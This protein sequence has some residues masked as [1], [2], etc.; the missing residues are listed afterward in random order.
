LQ[1]WS[2]GKLVRHSAQLPEF[3]YHWAAP[4][5]LPHSNATLPTLLCDTQSQNC[6]IATII[7]WLSAQ[8]FSFT[9]F[10]EILKQKA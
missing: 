10:V 1:G 9:F 6:C 2:L 4:T 3:N 8:K 7:I 5:A